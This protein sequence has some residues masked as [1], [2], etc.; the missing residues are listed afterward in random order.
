VEFALVGGLFF[1]LVFG[2]VNGG[3]GLYS[4]NAIQ[5]A[6]DV[7]AGVIADEGNLVTADTDGIAAMEQA[8]L[9]HV[10]LTTVT[11]ITLQEE[12]SCTYSD[13]A[14]LT[15]TSSPGCPGPPSGGYSG[16]VLSPDLHGCGGYP[17]EQQY[18][19]SAGAWSCTGT[20][21]WAPGV[22]VI[23]QGPDLSGSPNFARLQIFYTF[24]TVAA[25]NT[26]NL[27]ATVV[28]RLEPQV[29]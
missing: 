17:C 9:T 15:T 23:T 8:G 20:C 12:D 27:T 19:L 26:F 10:V 5:H 6:A 21:D 16:Q 25:A 22:R 18:T 3:F 29:L 14:L 13:G 2:V 11:G 4:V 1:F 28:F 24:S 7:G